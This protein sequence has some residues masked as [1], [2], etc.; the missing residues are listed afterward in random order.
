MRTEILRMEHIHKSFTGVKVLHNMKLNLFKGEVLG[1]IGLNGSGKTT[2]FR[3]LTGVCPKDKGTIYYH[4]KSVQ[5]HSP[6]DALALGIYMIDKSSVLIP[7]L[8]VAENLDILTGKIGKKIVIRKK[9]VLAHAQRLLESVDV[10]ANSLVNASSLSMFEQHMILIASAMHIGAKVIILDSITD[11]YSQQDIMN[12][13]LQVE[14]LKQKGISIII[15][16]Y[17]L[18]ELMEITDRIH[19]IRDGEHAGTCYKEEYSKEKLSAML[20]GSAFTDSFYKAR[21]ESLETVL[22]V[23]HLSIPNLLDNVSFSLNK[24]EIKG[25]VDFDNSSV[26]ALVEVLLGL[27]AKSTGTI[28]LEGQRVN[29]KQLREAMDYGIGY[30]PDDELSA[31]IFPNMTVAQNITFLVCHKFANPLAYMKRY[32]ERFFLNEIRDAIPFSDAE[33]K[34]ETARL[35]L[36]KEER[37]NILIQR[38]LALPLKVLIVVNPTKGLDIASRRRVQLELQKAAQRNITI[39]LISSDLSETFVMSDKVIVMNKGKVVGEIFSAEFEKQ[40]ILDMLLQ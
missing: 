16:G 22:E 9:K 20:V 26:T 32:L 2:L 21:P 24:G 10:K 31:G 7:N 36:N 23:N 12:M 3:I 25:F 38:L 39:L 6:Q 5:I 13:R 33:M 27:R 37:Q 1:V 14:Q 35:Q 17:K 18:G 28:S 8:S 11:T 30:L 40:K 29:F 15:T 4:E 19:V 34:K